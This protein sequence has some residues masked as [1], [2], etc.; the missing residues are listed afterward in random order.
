MNIGFLWFNND[1]QTTLQQ[2]IDE[3]AA[4]LSEKYD[5][6]INLCYLHPDMNPERLQSCNGIAIKHSKYVLM[7]HFW[8]GQS[9]KE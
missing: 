8:L 3:A 2:K 6:P 1:S 5:R 4:Y 9:E 7:N